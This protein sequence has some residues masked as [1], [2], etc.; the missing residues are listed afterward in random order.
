MYENFTFQAVFGQLFQMPRA[1][2]VEI[3]Y[4]A[5]LI[6]LCRLQ[7][8]SM[9]QVVSFTRHHIFM[10]R[11]DVTHHLIVTHGTNLWNELPEHVKF[12]QDSPAFKTAMEGLTKSKYF[13]HQFEVSLIHSILLHFFHFFCYTAF[14]FI[15]HFIVCMWCV[16]GPLENH[17]LYL[18]WNAMK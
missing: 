17:I 7:P 16:A 12:R 1:P 6:E 11:Y 3:F 8:G 13:F 2:H 15:F 14:I 9:P 5:L 18:E 10:R 4:G